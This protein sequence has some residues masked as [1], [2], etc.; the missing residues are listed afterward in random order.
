M[1]LF[2][3]VKTNIDTVKAAELYGINVNRHGKALCPF[4]NDHHPSLLVTC[5]H[6]HCFACNEHGDAIDLVAKLFNLSLYEAAKKLAADFGL[7]PGKPPT[8]STQNNLKRKTEAQQL[9]ENE[10]LCFLILNKYCRLLQHWKNEYAP[11]TPDEPDDQRF[12][13]ACHKLP[14]VEYYL[15]LLMTGDSIESAEAVESLL[16]DGKLQKL[17]A[18]LKNAVKEA[19]SHER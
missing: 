1:N 17:Q 9:R 16:R 8:K 10:R 15:D 11:S 19:D 2:T 12:V 14:A 5:D 13:E 6:Y 3:T 7:S 4:H 18:H